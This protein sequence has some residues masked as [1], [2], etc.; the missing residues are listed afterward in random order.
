MFALLS[1]AILASLSFP[2]ETLAQ[3]YT[4]WSSVVFSRTGERTPEALGSLPVVLTPLGANQ[5]YNAGAYLRDRYFGQSSINGIST[6]PIQGL[7]SEIIQYNQVYVGTL[8]SQYMAASA[9]AFMQGL[10][11]PIGAKADDN[12]A[13]GDSTLA[14]GTVVRFPAPIDAYQFINT[15]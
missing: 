6:A 2:R 10:Y 3:G 13:A 15:F 5:S 8:D 11:P 1:T 4:V 9:Q 12:T 7:S 14:D